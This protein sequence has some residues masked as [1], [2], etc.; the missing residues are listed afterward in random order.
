MRRRLARLAGQQP[1]GAA[2]AVVVAAIWAPQLAPYGAKD[3]AFAPYA[4]PGP[5]HPMGTDQLG[6]D[7]LS[8]VVWG[9]ACRS[10]SV[11]CRWCS[12]SLWA[13]SGAW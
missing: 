4:P 5:G 7:V 10:T 11:S 12:A 3:A 6:R 8:R 13:V 9:H 2:G 1:L